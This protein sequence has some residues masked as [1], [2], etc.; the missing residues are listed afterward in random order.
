VR[1]SSAAFD[2]QRVFQKRQRAGAVQNLSANPRLKMDATQ[3]QKMRRIVI[4]HLALTIFCIIATICIDTAI[5]WSGPRGEAYNR[6]LEHQAINEA[7]VNFIDQLGIILQPQ[8]FILAKVIKLDFSNF[9]LLFFLTIPLWSFCFGWLFV[10]FD[11][12]PNH[13]PVPGKKVF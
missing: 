2:G 8:F 12:W 10:K 7:W 9:A 6:A 1:Q 5:H 13:F 4:G 11:N 3:K